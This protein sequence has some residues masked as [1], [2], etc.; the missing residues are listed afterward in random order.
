MLHRT[1]IAASVIAAFG[2]VTASAEAHPRLRN[3]SPSPGATLKSAPKEIRMNFSEGL[4]AQFTGVDLK[5]AHGHRVP[6]GQAKVDPS[7]NTKLVV[8]IQA[9]LPA[10]K[11][12]VAW[13]AVSVDTHR[14]S[15]NYAFRVSR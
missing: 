9:R 12:N 8:A 1:I 14:V 10:G 2:L 6:T 3:A 4:V 15:G 7:D 13:H 5:D 11:Y